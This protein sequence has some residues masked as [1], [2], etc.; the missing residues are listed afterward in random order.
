MSEKTSNASFEFCCCGLGEKLHFL[1]LVS[2]SSI[3]LR[4]R[5]TCSFDNHSMFYFPE[6][7]ITYDAV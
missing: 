6:K 7:G 3:V 5:L 4:I 1:L 2:H